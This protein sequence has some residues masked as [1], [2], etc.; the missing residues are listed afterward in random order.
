MLDGDQGIQPHQ[1]MVLFEP[2][3]PEERKEGGRDYSAV[4]KVRKGG[5][6]KWELVS[7]RRWFVTRELWCAGLGLL[8]S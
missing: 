1:A 6:G 2:V 4:V 8:G 5:K 3:D 7:A